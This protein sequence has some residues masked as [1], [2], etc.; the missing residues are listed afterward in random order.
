MTDLKLP[1]Y[2]TVV[3]GV[4]HSDRLRLESL[5]LNVG[6]VYVYPSDLVGF[7]GWTY[8]NGAFRLKNFGPVEFYGHTFGVTHLQ[9]QSKRGWLKMFPASYHWWSFLRLQ[10]KDAQGGWLPGTELGLYIRKGL[11][12]IFDWQCFRWDIAGT[13]INGILQH[14]IT[15][16]GFCGGHWD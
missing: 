14:W 3:E 4:V 5:D 7:S 2:P 10:K 1:N 6:D 9:K 15:S 13:R 12:G 11:N 8:S 16:S